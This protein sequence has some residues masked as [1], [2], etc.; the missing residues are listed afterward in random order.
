[1]SIGLKAILGLSQIKES[2]KNDE[3]DFLEEK[4]SRLSLSGRNSL[5]ILFRVSDPGPFPDPDSIR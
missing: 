1:M 3:Q 5:S 4:D 2:C